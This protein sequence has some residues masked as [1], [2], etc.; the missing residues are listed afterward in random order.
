[1]DINLLVAA[2][3]LYALVVIV[4]LVYEERDPS[5]TLA[6]I[7]VILLLPVA[8]LVLYALFGR[9]WRRIGRNDRKLASATRAGRDRMAPL[10]ERFR[11]EAS[12][13]A[14]DPLEGHV[15]RSIA[16]QSGT[17]P[18]PC[19]GLEIIP[20]GA[21]KFERLLTDIEGARHHV[22]LEYFIWEED[23]LTERFC[24][25]LAQKA[26]DGV[27]VRVLYDWVGSFFHGKSQLRRLARAGAQVRADAANW[28][29]LNYRNHRK[30]VV[31]DGETVYTGGMNLG[32]EYI[33]GG[34]RF[35][36]WR[37][38]HLRFAGPLVSDL[39][40]LFCVRWERLTGEDLFSD[41]YFPQ[42][43]DP[44]PGSWVWAQLAYSGPETP[45]QAIRQSYLVAIGSARE[46][47]WLQSP[48]YVPD[49]SIAD[50]LEGQALAGVDVRLMMTGV[51][52]KRIAWWAAFSYLDE[53]LR[54]GGA[55]LQ[56]KAGFFHAKTLTIDGRIAA[57]GTTNLDIRSF[58]LHDELQVF[59]YD[60]DIAARQDALFEADAVR[61]EE[62]SL[63]NV[64][65][66]GRLKRLRNAVARLASRML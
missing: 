63:E 45:W 16:V 50:T 60:R 62:L 19:V 66:A 4:T 32:Q 46:R 24:A 37:D 14:S 56:Y 9:D 30:M 53:L 58:A 27:E 23:A 25:L 6:W 10:Y 35:A 8:G 61:C 40:A 21:E 49:Q 59:F 5:T 22:H 48:Y 31:I 12:P 43:E 54:A 38:T 34:K 2:I 55:V 13:L 36:T 11:F 57:I 39:Q 51:A 41:A 17:R 29:K 1:M 47:V 18:L 28:Q 15:A 42:H 64:T 7:L 65:R 52:D 20:T 26:A 33:D 44:E 3:Y